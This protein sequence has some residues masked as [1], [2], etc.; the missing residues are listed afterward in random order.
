MEAADG[1]AELLLSPT[2]LL[3]L[4]HDSELQLLSNDLA[5]VRLRIGEGSAV[6]ELDGLRRA[7]G[8]RFVHDPLLVECGAAVVQLEYAGRY[9]FDCSVDRP[10][11]RLAVHRGRAMVETAAGGFKVGKRQATSLA[12]PGSAHIER[13]GGGDAFDEWSRQRAS[14]LSKTRKRMRRRRGPTD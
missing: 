12:W 9:R 2:A 10:G 13:L 3:W 11:S 7:G 14:R 5:R 8:R 6:I 4:D 1:R